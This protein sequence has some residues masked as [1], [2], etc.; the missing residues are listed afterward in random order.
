MYD[1]ANSAFTTSVI[2]VFFG[3][4]LTSL[5]LDNSK[6]DSMVI[7]LG[8]EVYSPSL[9]SY[10]ISIS[11]FLQALLMPIIGSYV[12]LLANKKTPLLFFAYLGAFS[13][14]ALYFFDSSTLLLGCILLIIANI[15]FGV[16]IVIYNSILND[17]A[18]KQESEKIS[19]IGWAIGYLGGGICLLLDLILFSNFEMLGITKG[20]AVRIAL[21]SAGIWWAVFTLF[22]LLYLK[23]DN[24]KLQKSDRIVYSAFQNLLDTLKH[25]R[26]YPRTY[27]FLIAFL[28]YNDGVQA[29]ITFAAVFGA[30]E[31]KLEQSTLISA[32]LLVQFIAFLGALFFGKLSERVGS[33]KVLFINI[34][35]WILVLVYTFGFVKSSTDFYIAASVIAVVLGGIQAISRGVYARLIPKGYE[36]KYFS[37]YEITDRGTSW[38]GTLLFGL[39][40]E[41]SKSYRFAILSL[42]LFFLIGFILLI[43]WNKQ[44]VKYVQ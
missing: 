25:I 33:T 12:D 4:Y 37:F 40:L 17:I 28:F 3:P 19:S 16:S 18:Y 9:F 44:E 24:S 22:P 14:I 31:L 15:A 8:M 35:I 20:E 41:L 11:V 7:I 36:A 23:S 38:A 13:T 1:F 2:T 5:A 27:R 26:N 42:I 21:A 6:L 39:V 29:V 43:Y 32:I 10:I 30:Y 34:V